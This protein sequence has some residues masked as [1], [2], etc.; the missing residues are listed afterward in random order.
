MG[1]A[2]FKNSDLV[3]LDFMEMAKADGAKFVK[4]AITAFKSS[5]YTFLP[6]ISPGLTRAI[7]GL[8]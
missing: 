6:S 7:L 2:V 4:A 3:F 1:R 8:L 5:W